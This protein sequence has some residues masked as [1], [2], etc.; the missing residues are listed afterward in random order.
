[1][2][3]DVA[4]R[5]Q[6]AIVARITL[7]RDAAVFRGASLDLAE[8]DENA[9]PKFT[10]SSR[11]PL[12]EGTTTL[13][14][15]SYGRKRLSIES[16][17]GHKLL[18]REVEVSTETTV[19][20]LAPV[21]IEVHGTVRRRGEG[22]A[23]ALVE[24]ADRHDAKMILG[25][26][27]ADSQGAYEITTYQSGEL[28]M[29]AMEPYR[30]GR[31]P[32][33]AHQNVVVTAPDYRA[34]FEL[35]ASGA[36]V[37][38]VDAVTGA[39]IRATIDKRL[40]FDSGGGTMGITD[41]DDDGRLVFD[42]Y[43]D[44]VAHLH[45]K[46]AGYR[47]RE[48]DVPLNN[49]AAESTVALEKGGIVTGHVMGA[50]GAPVAGAHISGGYTDEMS[51]QGHFDTVSDPEGRFQFDSAPEP[52]TMFYIAATGYA[53]GIT[54]L[55]AGYENTVTLLPPGRGAV[56]LLPGNAPPARPQFVMASPADGDYIPQ[57][58]LMDL[59][60]LNGMNL[61]QLISTARDGSVVL[62]QFLPPGIFNLYIAR[63][64]GKPYIFQKVGTV[65]LPVHGTAAIAYRDQ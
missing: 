62:P 52:D 21:P 22:V 15:Q 42:G 38:I 53:L 65:T 14:L 11:V 39:P 57:G 44:G 55:R 31:A 50:N 47:A 9:H 56:Y 64:G 33:V 60:D 18:F 6:A 19:V 8:A 32:F 34:D 2:L 54:T 41:T 1:V 26:A 27:A 46:A 49:S 7:P 23:G 40:T 37:R 48:I 58:A 30:R 29:D 25:S 20:D 43:P 35:P 16:S 36:S 3:A 28:W 59:A 63:P 12:H 13:T 45:V 61:F 51:G 5:P 24:L 4:L 10:S 17:S